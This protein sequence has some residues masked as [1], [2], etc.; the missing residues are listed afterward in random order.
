MA[1]GSFCGKCGAEAVDPNDAFCR[2]CG[3]SL[4][5]PSQA[6]ISEDRKPLSALVYTVWFRAFSLVFAFVVIGGLLSLAFGPAAREMVAQVLVSTPP[7]ENAMQVP[8]MPP[9]PTPLLSSASTPTPVPTPT[10]V[11][12][13][14]PVPTPSLQEA[15]AKVQSYTAG[16]ITDLGSGSGAV[17]GGGYILTAAHVVQGANR[18]TVFVVGGQQGAADLVGIDLKRDLALLYS[19]RAA[20]PGLVWYSGAPLQAGDKI[21]VVGYPRPD[22][23]GLE[24]PSLTQGVFSSYWTNSSGVRFLQT[25]APMNPG[26]S[27]GPVAD[28]QGRLVGIADF[29]VREAVGLNYAVAVSEI[30]A[31]LASPQGRGHASIPYNVSAVHVPTGTSS[32]LSWQS[33]SAGATMDGY[34]VVGGDKDVGFSLVGPDGLTV[35]NPGRIKGPYAF[36]VPI[37]RTGAY[38]MVFDNSY[39]IFTSKNITAYYRVRPSQ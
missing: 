16:V 21:L 22:V 27:G 38:A 32:K 7:T 12:T 15:A 28:G 4:R 5:V 3:A 34:F 36:S 37:V 20:G 39:S 6:E 30:D 1:I 2:K 11:P 35:F 26:N 25:D 24:G 31:F 18:I 13:P 17:L 19:P 8:T 33:L 14:T 9:V 23:I 29:I 10:T